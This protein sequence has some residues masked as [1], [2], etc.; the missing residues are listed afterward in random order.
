[1]PGPITIILPKKGCIPDN[2]TCGL[3]TVGIRMPENIIARELI[4][5][6]V[7]L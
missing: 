1:M 5:H 2:V 4:K 3:K 6:Q 7:S